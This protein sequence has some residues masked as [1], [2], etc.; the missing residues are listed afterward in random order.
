MVQDPS[1]DVTDFQDGINK[2]SNKYAVS[3]AQRFVPTLEK[4]LHIAQAL[5]QQQGSS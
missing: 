5:Q 4:H 1:N 2:G 3:A